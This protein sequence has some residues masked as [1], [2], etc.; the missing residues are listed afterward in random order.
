MS[1]QLGTD[2]LVQLGGDSDFRDAADTPCE[3]GQI[4]Q[5]LCDQRDLDPQ[6]FYIE[7][8]ALDSRLGFFPLKG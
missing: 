6:C 1:L 2:G 5:G 4:L 8:Q 7:R 3:H